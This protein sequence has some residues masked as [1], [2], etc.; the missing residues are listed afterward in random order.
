MPDTYDK[1]AQEIVRRILDRAAPKH[2]GWPTPEEWNASGISSDELAK[3]LAD[4]M[5]DL[6]T[7]MWHGGANVQA[8]ADRGVGCA[9]YPC[10]YD[11]CPCADKEAEEAA[12]YVDSML[13]NAKSADYGR[14]WFDGQNHM[15]ASIR[16]R[17]GKKRHAQKKPS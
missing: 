17:K 11:P 6:S 14:G 12:K 7:M 16:A 13:T 4:E 15:A 5:R 3:L 9:I 1:R 10:L 8:M 2:T